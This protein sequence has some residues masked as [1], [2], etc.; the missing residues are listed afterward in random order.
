MSLSLS[1]GK[2]VSVS[3]E[4]RRRMEGMEMSLLLLTEV[5]DVRADSDDDMW[6]GEPVRWCCDISR[7]CEKMTTL[8]VETSNES[9]Q[10]QEKKLKGIFVGLTLGVG[11]GEKR[12]VNER[13]GK[14]NA[15]DQ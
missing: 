4:R 7:C 10:N 15:W 12:S 11:N 9:T 1:E 5:R 2:T 6:G 14:V 13:S 8:Y 3:E